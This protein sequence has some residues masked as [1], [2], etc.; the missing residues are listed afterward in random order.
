M[1]K[2]LLEKSNEEILSEHKSLKI[3]LIIATTAYVIYL[4]IIFYSFAVDKKSISVFVLGGLSAMY[5]FTIRIYK[6]YE[7]EKKR[8]NL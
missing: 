5:L 8:R 4:G 3:L 7:K 1:N 6:Q 2:N